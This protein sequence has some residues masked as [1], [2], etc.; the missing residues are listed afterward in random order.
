VI[1]K[2]F[3][4][5]INDVRDDLLKL[6]DDV[7]SAMLHAIRSLHTHNT[8]TA[9]WVIQ[10]D[11][12]IDQARRNLEERVIMLFATQQPIVASDLRLLSVVSAIATELERIGDY[13]CS[14]ARRV[15]RAPDHAI[16]V[17]LPDG[18]NRMEELVQQMLKT[19]LEAFLQQDVEMARSLGVIDEEVDRLEDQLRG[20]LIALIDIDKRCVS[21]VLDLI[22]VVHALE[23]A[24][25]RTTNIGERVI[26][27]VT[28]DMEEI[29]P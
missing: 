13:A 4:H 2:R 19:C 12:Q 18:I 17:A 23:R 9:L 7:S 22:E 5:L 28:N 21:A 27:M 29:N 14:I 16:Q 11:T 3:I 24:A 25:D 26:Y 1:R 6:G 8:T 10:N 15:Y 20:E